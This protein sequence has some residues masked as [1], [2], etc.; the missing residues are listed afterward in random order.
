MKQS[1]HV[2]VPGQTRQ[3]LHAEIDRRAALHGEYARA[4]NFGNDVE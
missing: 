1:D 3:I 2:N 4:K